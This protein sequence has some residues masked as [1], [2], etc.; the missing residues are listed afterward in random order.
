MM[1]ELIT[2]LEKTTDVNGAVILSDEE[3]TET[4]N[5]IQLAMLKLNRK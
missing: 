4:D 2:N 5:V 1:N 3:R